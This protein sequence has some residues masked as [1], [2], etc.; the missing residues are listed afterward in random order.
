MRGERRG[1]RER[2]HPTASYQSRKGA[3]MH[4][5]S[6]RRGRRRVCKGQYEGYR[7]SWMAKLA[8]A[9]AKPYYLVDAVKYNI[10]HSSRKMGQKFGSRKSFQCLGIWC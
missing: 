2:E 3:G 4:G 9:L 10:A 5:Q 7:G 8:L 1:S 6:R